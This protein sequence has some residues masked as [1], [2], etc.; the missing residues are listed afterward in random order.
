MTYLL[1]ERMPLSRGT[2]ASRIWNIVPSPGE[3]ALFGEGTPYLSYDGRMQFLR[4]IYA[5]IHALKS[6]SF[7]SLALWSH[8]CFS[9]EW[10]AFL[11]WEE[12]RGPASRTESYS[13]AS[14]MVCWRGI[15]GCHPGSPLGYRSTN[16]SGQYAECKLLISW[17]VPLFKQKIICRPSTFSPS[18]PGITAAI[19]EAVGKLYRLG[20]SPSST[21]WHQLACHIHSA[22]QFLQ[23]NL[24]NGMSQ[25]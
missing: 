14:L 10:A 5:A 15:D 16:C 25:S 8:S 9:R 11:L 20:S 13:A 12:F 7:R 22:R 1:W 2:I 23:L 6:T 17:T 24:C 21:W 3:I 4:L 18:T 19:S